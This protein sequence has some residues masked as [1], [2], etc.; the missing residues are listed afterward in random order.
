MFTRGLGG[1]VQFVWRGPSRFWRILLL[2]PL[3]AEN[4]FTYVNCE[5]KSSL[6]LYIFWLERQKNSQFFIIGLTFSIWKIEWCSFH[7]W[8]NYLVFREQSFTVHR[9]MVWIVPLTL[10]TLNFTVC[11]QHVLYHLQAKETKLKLIIFRQDCFLCLRILII[12]GV[13]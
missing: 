3:I 13:F 12:E 6:L 2:L 9:S 7:Y 11:K 5:K 8:S 10:E 4:L 1:S